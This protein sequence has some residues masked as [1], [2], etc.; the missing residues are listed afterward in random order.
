MAQGTRAY[1]RMGEKC[2]TVLLSCHEH[3]KTFT[4]NFTKKMSVNNYRCFIDADGISTYSG[5]V[6]SI[7]APPISQQINI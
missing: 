6:D 1:K 2:Y 7:R 4:M 3:K 5:K